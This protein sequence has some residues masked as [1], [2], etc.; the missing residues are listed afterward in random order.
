MSPSPLEFVRHI[1]DEAAYLTSQAHHLTKEELVRNETL[2]RAFVRSLEV[3]GEAAKK[4]PMEFRSRHGDVEWRAMA[5]MR[6]R[7]IHDYFGV[8]YDIVWDVVPNKLPVLTRQLQDIVQ[9]E[10]ID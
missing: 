8:D 10:S 2:K 3:I 9:R 4:V 1:L 6:D 7:L 5:G